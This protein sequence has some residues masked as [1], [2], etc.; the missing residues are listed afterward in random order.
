MSRNYRRLTAELSWIASGQG[1]GMLGSLI[2]VRILTS[3]LRPSVYGEISLV[4]ATSAIVSTLLFGPLQQGMLRFFAPAAEAEQLPAFIFG[5]RRLLRRLTGLVVALAVAGILLLS[6]FGLWKWVVLMATASLLALL[7]GYERA[8]DALQ[9]AARQRAITAWHQAII[10]WGFLCILPAVWLL[11][12]SSS[13][14]MLGYLAATAFVLLSQ[15]AFF[16]A[17]YRLAISAAAGDG[18]S[19]DWATRI[20]HY[21]TPFML[22]AIFPWLQQSTDR[23]GL[24]VFR[25]AHD[26]GLYA[27]LL[28]LGFQPVVLVSG[29][30]VQLISPIVFEKAGSG[31]D[32][33]RLGE[34]R[35]LT[36]LA[37]GL[38]LVMT[39]LGALFA[40][41]F[42][43]PVFSLFLAKQYRSVIPLMPWMILAGGFF[44]AG[45]VAA[46]GLMSRMRTQMLV[47]PQIVTGLLGAV[48]NVAGAAWLGIRGVVFANVCYGSIYLV[49]MLMLAVPERRSIIAAM[50]RRFRYAIWCSDLS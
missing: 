42:R 44:A 49:W 14:A 7:T 48:L 25:S 40:A 37:V 19:A 15:Y 2:G 12:P 32:P 38:F 24:Q 6:I 41:V 11:G 22:F 33:I 17:R 39:A 16:R 46:L 47:L 1:F 31:L 50:W 28:Q 3:V 35:K 9:S 23:W 18:S 13:A 29:V 27:V 10:R 26:I 30:F 36:F 8:L 4:L 43:E 20:Q 34:A 21:A 5:A 45:Q